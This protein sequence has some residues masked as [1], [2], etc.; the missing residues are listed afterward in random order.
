MVT[1]TDR[2]IEDRR[3]C[4]CPAKRGGD[5]G[6]REIKGDHGCIYR[7]IPAKWILRAQPSTC[8]STATVEIPSP[9]LDDCYMTPWHGRYRRTD[10]VINVISSH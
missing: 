3:Q 4:C 6:A 2:T 9:T 10:L 7:A 5:I 1:D 8:V